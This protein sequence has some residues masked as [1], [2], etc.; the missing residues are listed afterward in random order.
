M[1]PGGNLEFL[2]PREGEP[3]ARW[4]AET[5]GVPAFVLRYRLLPAHGRDAAASRR[6]TSS[7]AQRATRRKESLES[8]ES[9]FLLLLLEL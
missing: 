7:L 1:C 8:L 3:V 2:H 4:L 6:S 5:F 9:L